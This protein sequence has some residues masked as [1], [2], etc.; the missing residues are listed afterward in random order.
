MTEQEIRD[1]FRQAVGHDVSTGSHT[2]KCPDCE[3]GKVTT[4]TGWFG[5]VVKTHS[6]W[7]CDGSGVVTVP[8]DP[9]WG[10]ALKM[11]LREAA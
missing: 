9:K 1:S 7:L 2:E 5:E 8:D 4:R 11:E 10:W 3:G 6:C